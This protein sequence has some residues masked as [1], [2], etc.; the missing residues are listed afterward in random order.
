MSYYDILKNKSEEEIDYL[1]GKIPNKLPQVYKGTKRKYNKAKIHNGI[2]LSM[3][4]WILIMRELNLRE[5][6]ELLSTSKMFQLEMVDDFTFYQCLHNTRIYDENVYSENFISTIYFHYPN[7]F[8]LK[9]K[10][11]QKIIEC[12]FLC[13]NENPNIGSYPDNHT[14]IVCK[15]FFKWL[16]E[17]KMTNMK[18]ILSFYHLFLPNMDGKYINKY[19][20]PMMKNI[21]DLLHNKTDICYNY[22]T[23]E[24]PYPL[25][26]FSF[27][28]YGSE[29][30]V[31]TVFDWMWQIIEQVKK[32]KESY[33]Y[34]PFKYEDGSMCAFKTYDKPIA[35]A[36][37]WSHNLNIDEHYPLVEYVESM[38]ADFGWNF[39]NEFREITSE[40]IKLYG[41][42]HNGIDID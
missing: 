30:M 10:W 35:S 37:Y 33:T 23:I 6:M 22:T 25:I 31:R 26:V 8:S 39:A 21:I 2:L 36:Y 40:S 19:I 41:E 18:L 42:W 14:E 17:D 4:M 32:G 13:P 27:S 7:L 34:L 16:L 11:I 15:Y 5:L 28:D 24:V 9:R 1:I 12:K 3:D 29:K 38:N 20:P